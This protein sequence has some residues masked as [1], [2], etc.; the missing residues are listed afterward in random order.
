M[1][2]DCAVRKITDGI[3]LRIGEDMTNEEQIEVAQNAEMWLERA[4]AYC[5]RSDYPAAMVAIVQ[6]T[7]KAAYNRRGDEGAN[8]SSVGGQSMNYEDLADTMYKR[9]SHEGLRIYKL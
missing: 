1:M 8:S 2:F 6:E 5:N 9:L 4:S 3:A 7:V